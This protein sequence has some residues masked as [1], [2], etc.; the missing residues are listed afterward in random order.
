MDIAYSRESVLLDTGGGLLGAKRF[1]DQRTFV[2]IDRDV[3]IDWPLDEVLCKLRL[4]SCDGLP[5]AACSMRLHTVTLRSNNGAL[6]SQPR[7]LVFPLFGYLS[8]TRDSSSAS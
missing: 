7:S 4:R 5:E 6:S 3:L 8:G 1:L 2:I